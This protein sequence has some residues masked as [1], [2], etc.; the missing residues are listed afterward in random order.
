MAVAP[1][2]EAPLG[3]ARPR[4]PYVGLVPYDESDAAFF[5]GRST[6]AAIVAA[7]LRA[8]RLTILYGPSGVGKTSLLMA[9]AVHDLHEDA[10]SAEA[11][12]PFAVCVFRSWRDDP[13]PGLREAARAALEEPAGVRPLP[14]P[15]GT[16]AE[17]LR[18]WTER[19]GTLLVV[20]DQFEEYFQYHPDE[21]DD[22][23]LTGFAAELAL[24]VNDPSLPVNV[25]LSIREDAWAKLDRFE[26][27]IPALFAN[28]VRVDHLDLES[29]REAIVGPIEVWN[30]SLPEGEQPFEIEPALVD[31]VLAA[32]AS[33]SLTLTAG[34]EGPAV[35]T[36]GDR[37]EAPFLQLVL[38]RLWRDTVADGAHTLTLARLESLGGARRIVENHLLDALA[39]LD[40]SEQDIAAGC[41]R[42]LVSSGKTKIAHPAADLAEWTQEPEPQITA[43]LDKLCSAESGR[44]LRVVPPAEEGGSNSYELF[45]D[46]LAEPILA[47]RRGHEQERSRQAARKRVA[48][49]GLA[50]FLLGLLP[51][52]VGLT[53]WALVK[54]SDAGRASASA[55]SLALSFPANSQLANHL[56]V[57]L[58]LSLA[59]YRASPTAEARSSMISALEAARSSSLQ[60]VL[61]GVRG[62]VAGVA[63]SP[64]GSTLAVAGQDGTVRLW[65]AGKSP[66]HQLGELAGPEGIPVA[67]VAFSRD[68]RTLAAAY[69]NGTLRLWSVP[70]GSQLGRVVGPRGTSFSGVALSADGHTLA[71]AG[72]DG[73]VRIWDTRTSP[74][75]PLGQLSGP[76]GTAVTGVALDPDARTL[77]A[78]Y[79]DGTVRLWDAAAHR[80]LALLRGPGRTSA[81]GVAFDPEGHTLAVSYGDGTVRLWDVATHRQLGRLVGPDRATSVVFSPDGRLLAAAY[82]GGTVLV[83]NPRS[84]T[85]LDRLAG[86]KGTS[87]TGVTFDRDSRTLAAAF[88]PGSGG[89]GTVRLWDVGANPQQQFGR[90]DGPAGT[91]VSGVAFSPDRRVLATAGSDGVVR[92]WDVAT[93]A[94]LGQLSSPDGTPAQGVGFS[95]DKRT[96]AVAY[97]DGTVR[98]WDVSASPYRQLG[99]LKGPEGI[100]P[101]GVAFSSDEHT[102]AAAYADGTLLLWNVGTSPYR[103]LGELRGPSGVPTTGVAI[104]P[105][106]RT[107]AASYYDGTIRLWNVR[108]RMPVGQPL[109]APENAALDGPYVVS[110]VAF[111]PDGRTLVAAGSDARLRL[112]DVRTETPVGEPLARADGT[113]NGVAVSSDGTV[114]SGSY[115]PTVSLWGGV[116][117]SG[118]DALKREVCSLV[119]GT[120]SKAEWHV[121]APDLSYRASC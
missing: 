70:A 60:G 64:D 22:E 38:E 111:S 110:G 78:A 72:S 7:N 62:P 75:R 79:F 121:L 37:I 31:A 91:S 81:A 112:W 89:D 52:F 100:A 40:P 90:L 48:R 101:T 115:D 13:V 9:G 104:S 16:L 30:R 76:H 96:L 102:L 50:A 27:H 39:L 45:H 77:A 73:V 5:F 82:G 113:V 61:H 53:I 41:F 17:T 98:L 95:P 34:G 3:V 23:R 19:A 36:P 15:A 71:A 92:F 6:E 10:R 57:A 14:P 58:L 69:G 46:I 25:L 97:Q 84:R 88:N 108:S 56:D 105:D 93:R 1:A 109:R 20:F 106:G 12:S 86:P 67:G 8:S 120:L 114:A 99:L 80:Q 54:S 68:G 24:V 63:F 33:G 65:D 18:A 55:T 74:Y 11:E 44:I 94:Q 43:V 26:G 107:L 66:H 117:W 59:A 87:V 51:V 118:I 116:L 29:A 85:Q 119:W 32:T 28:Y 47:W 49:I 35:E 42:F 103:R 2:A 21:G 83:W 4:S